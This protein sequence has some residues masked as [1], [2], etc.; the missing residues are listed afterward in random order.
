[1]TSVSFNIPKSLQDL[2]P[3]WAHFCLHIEKF[4]KDDL[5]VDLTSKR[6][7]TAF[8]GGVDSTALL[9]VLHYLSLKN[10]GQ[11]VAVHL[12]HNLR[13]EAN[14]DARWVKSICRSINIECVVE[15]INIKMLS[16][17]SGVGI[18]EAGRNARYDLFQKVLAAKSADYIAIGHHLNDLCEDV[19][20]RLTRGTGWP[21]LSGMAGS[22]PTRN[23]VRPFLLTSK[24]MLIDFL[25]DIGLGWREDISNADP[26]WMRNR[27]RNDILP[28]FLK[29]NPNFPESIARLWKLGKIEEAYWGNQTKNITDIIS[30][31]ILYDAHQALRLRL[32]KAALDKLGDGQA[33]AD[34]LF[35]LDKAW[36]EKRVGSIFQFP[37]GKIGTIVA[38]GVLFSSTH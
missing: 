25:T 8:S 6:V 9:L 27:I 30:N 18:E 13:T 24:T 11:V 2:P 20:M 5:G 37:E 34:T 19:L 22:D 15:S 16:R 38:T 32:Y 4:I 29:E 33:L 14:D 26:T 21:G 3:K 1:M 12:N 10:G 28:L 7:V 35:K 23:L 36:L 17:D 31:D